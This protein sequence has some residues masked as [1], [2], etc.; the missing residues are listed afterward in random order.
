MQ[1]YLGSKDAHFQFGSF[2]IKTNNQ[3]EIK[4]IKKPKPVQ[5]NLFWFGSVFSSF[6]RFSPVWLDSVFSM[7]GL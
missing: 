1:Q 5:S 2:F 6:P 3:T 4:K 7:S